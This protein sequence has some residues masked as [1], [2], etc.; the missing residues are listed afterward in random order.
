MKFKTV[1]FF[2]SIF[3]LLIFLNQFRMATKYE[4]NF[5]KE[6]HKNKF[7]TN[8]FNF[9]AHAGGGYDGKTY[10]NSLEAL[11][12]SFKKGFLLFEL[13]LLETTDNYLVGA[14]DWKGFKNDCRN[15]DFKNFPNLKNYTIDQDGSRNLPMSI[16]EFT[17]CKTNFTK[18]S[19]LQIVN[20][21]EKNKGAYLVTDQI[22]NYKLIRKYFSSRTIVEI[23]S[24]RDYIRAI[25][26]KTYIKMF[27]FSNGR[28]NIFYVKLFNIKIINIHSEHVEKYKNFLKNFI[29]KGN[30]VYVYTSNDPNFIKKNLNVT[31]SGFYTDFIDPKTISCTEPIKD[32]ISKSP[33]HTY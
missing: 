31:A 22:N 9:I 29:K 4:I 16:E 33:C 17:N 7:K 8:S 14:H 10:M 27:N 24:I 13:D 32:T 12:Y 3:F 18:I 30:I 2:F 15:Y 28:R 6:F 11:N 25:F 23:N 20:F 19:T 5:I 21:F 26:S 1:I